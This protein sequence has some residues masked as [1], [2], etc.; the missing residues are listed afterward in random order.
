MLIS[1]EQFNA[2]YKKLPFVLREYIAEDRLSEI[3]QQ[4][5]TS[6]GLHVDTVGA[7]YREA[8][9]M[10]LG[11]I[12]P[13]QFV[14]ELKTA[15]V[16]QESIASITL[17]LNEKVFVPLHKKMQEGSY[18]VDSE[19]AAASIEFPGPVSVAV[20]PI[21]VPPVVRPVT[22]PPISAPTPAPQPLPAIPPTPLYSNSP[23]ARAVPNTPIFDSTAPMREI[24]E[25]R[26]MAHDMQNVQKSPVHAPE[27]QSEASI[28]PTPTVQAPQ[29]QPYAPE[30]KVTSATPHQTFEMPVVPPTYVVPTAPPQPFTQKAVPPTPPT[31]NRDALYNVMKE[32]GVDPYRESPE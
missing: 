22:Q 17:E 24:P 13:E 15:G 4:I 21:A 9:N 29:T 18:E 8:T 14:T 28:H 1:S 7:V 2:A 31:G 27:H 23:D 32:Y 6:Y 19:P 5:G 20:S 30:P 26:T 11:L 3:T 12:N 16:A 10:L 25:V